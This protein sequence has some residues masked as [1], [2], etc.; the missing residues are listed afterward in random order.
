MESSVTAECRMVNWA[1]LVADQ[2]DGSPGKQ[3]SHCPQAEVEPNSPDT[4]NNQQ[5]NQGLLFRCFCDSHCWQAGRQAGRQ[6]IRSQAHRKISLNPKLYQNCIQH[7]I[8]TILFIYTPRSKY[9]HIML[10]PI[11]DTVAH[12]GHSWCH[13]RIC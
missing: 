13:V 9:Q 12:S 6:N 4:I 1:E 5:T 10:S 7:H 11:P 3:K 2:D 8:G